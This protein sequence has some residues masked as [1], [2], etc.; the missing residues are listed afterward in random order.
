MS[1]WKWVFGKTKHFHPGLLQLHPSLSLT[2]PTLRF[3]QKQQ[4]LYLQIFISK[5][6]NAGRPL[7][8]TKMIRWATLSSKIFVVTL[9]KC[10]ISI[11]CK[12]FLME[13]HKTSDSELKPF[14]FLDPKERFNLIYIY[15]II[16]RRILNSY[17]INE[18]KLRVISFRAKNK[19]IVIKGPLTSEIT[20]LR[21]RIEFI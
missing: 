14:T 13:N 16:S 6:K 3:Y 7:Q 19:I 2:L 20:S 18:R 9:L 17:R 4:N 11:R 8:R 12:F 21:L 10:M 1:R 15:L 5:L